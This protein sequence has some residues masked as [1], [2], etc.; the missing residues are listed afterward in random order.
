MAWPLRI[1]VPRKVYHVTVRAYLSGG[2][3]LGESAGLWHARFYGQAGHRVCARNA[4]MQDLT[5]FCCAPRAAP[6]LGTA[7]HQVLAEVV[8]RFLS[9]CNMLCNTAISL[10]IASFS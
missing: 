8:I 5:P 10:P 9:K 1:E 6:P 4:A 7:E 3:T 2:A